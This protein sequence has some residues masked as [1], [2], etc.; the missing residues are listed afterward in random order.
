[1]SN[2]RRDNRVRRYLSDPKSRDAWLVSTWYSDLVS[3]AIGARTHAGL[4][5]KDIAERIGT[6]QS[7]IARLENDLD[8]KVGAGRLVRY[9]IACGVVPTADAIPLNDALAHLTDAPSS[10]LRLSNFMSDRD[11]L[12]GNP[13]VVAA[14]PA[15]TTAAPS[16]L[17]AI[18]AVVAAPSVRNT[19]THAEA[20][21]PMTEVLRSAAATWAVQSEQLSQALKPMSDVFAGLNASFSSPSSLSA[22]EQYMATM[23]AMTDNRAVVSEAIEAGLSPRPTAIPDSRLQP[24]V[25][26]DRPYYRP[27]ADAPGFVDYVG[28]PTP[29][30]P[31]RP[32]TN[33]QQGPAAVDRRIAV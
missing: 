30:R 19:K 27:A 14:K 31:A 26:Q 4:T 33:S 7:A 24:V 15:E 17:P 13:D 16:A 6:T 21:A 3:Q 22:V 18:S 9:L 29:F 1:M 25:S 8:A 5:Q 2:D 11:D 20:L 32:Q 12:Q 10:D 28:R 23:R